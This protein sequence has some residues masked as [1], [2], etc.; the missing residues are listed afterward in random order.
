MILFFGCLFTNFKYYIF[1]SDIFIVILVS[2]LS[3]LGVCIENAFWYRQSKYAQINMINVFVLNDIDLCATYI[4]HVA[5]ISKNFTLMWPIL[6]DRSIELAV[7]D[8]CP[9]ISINHKILESKKWMSV[10]FSIRWTE[11]LIDL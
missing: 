3:I 6:F 9:I 5:S 7:V 10:I 4:W 1:N 2:P 11:H 8:F